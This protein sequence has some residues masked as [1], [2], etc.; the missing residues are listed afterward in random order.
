MNAAIMVMATTALTP[1]P[2]ATRQP[3]PQLG[4]SK[5]QPLLGRPSLQRPVPQASGS[6]VALRLELSSL[7]ATAVVMISTITQSA[8]TMEETVALVHAGV[9]SR[10]DL[11]GTIV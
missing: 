7:S 8:A 9:A 2:T 6:P 3:R 10:A 4:R 5:P 1:K 11:M